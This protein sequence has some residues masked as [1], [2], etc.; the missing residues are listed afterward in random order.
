VQ[1]AHGVIF[2]S[3]SFAGQAVLEL[4]LSVLLL[5]WPTPERWR[6][7]VHLAY[8]TVL[9]SGT[10]SLFLTLSVLRLPPV[11]APSGFSIFRHSSGAVGH[12]LEDSTEEGEGEGENSETLSARGGPRATP[13]QPE[14]GPRKRDSREVECGGLDDALASSES[15]FLS[16]QSSLLSMQTSLSGPLVAEE[17]CYLDEGS[18]APLS[19]GMEG[20]LTVPLLGSPVDTAHS[21]DNGR[22]LSVTS[23]AVNTAVRAVGTLRCSLCVSVLHHRHDETHCLGHLVHRR[24][25]ANNFG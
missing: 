1:D 3:T 22:Q 14:A 9:C 6:N 15:L 19:P 24:L 23:L 25:I 2:I 11:G 17:H 13:A 12:P 20:A 7:V 21:V 16:A 8:V 4:T 5:N 18:V 10:A